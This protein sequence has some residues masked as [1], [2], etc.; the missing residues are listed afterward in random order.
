MKELNALKNHE[1]REHIARCKLEV[2]GYVFN[3]SV[4]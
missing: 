3:R 2:A 4:S 1:E